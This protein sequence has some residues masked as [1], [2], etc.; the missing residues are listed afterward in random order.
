MNRKKHKTRV[1]VTACSLAFAGMSSIA[2]AQNVPNPVTTENAPVTLGDATDA[3]NQVREAADVVRQMEQEEGM[4]LLLQQAQG[5]FIVPDYARAALG[6]GVRGGEGVLLVKQDGEWSGPAFY[7]LGGVSV[8]LQGGVKA[9]DIAF[10]L[11]NQRAVNSF[12]QEN[13]WSLNADAGLTIVD[14]SATG[15]ASAGKGDV[16]AWSDT[17]GLFGNL[18][19]SISD[20]NFDEDETASYYGQQVALSEIVTGDVANPHSQQL[21]QA[22]AGGTPTSGSSD[23]AATGVVVTT[24]ATVIVPIEMRD[25][26]ALNNGCWVRL[27]SNPTGEKS[28]GGDMQAGGAANAGQDKQAGKAA[29]HSSTSGASARSGAA[30]GSMDPAADLTVAGDMELPRLGSAAGIDWS[31]KTDRV[32]VGPNATVTVFANEQFQGESQMLKAGQSIDNVRQQVGFAQ[33]INSMRVKCR[34]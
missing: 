26:P 33:S 21:Q 28:S 22:L 29:D 5:V 14:W 16:V 8:G 1:I 30:G 17:E 34:T 10:V 23:P 25:D 19:A 9:G 27:A 31:R 7:N 15:Q 18:A 13:N 6:I 4:D 3:L 2:F 32:V 11:N 20:I 24:P 12:M